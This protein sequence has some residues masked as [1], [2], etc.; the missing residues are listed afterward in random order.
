M[1]NST[2]LGRIVTH[3]LSGVKPAEVALYAEAAIRESQNNGHFNE[4][5]F[6]RLILRDQRLRADPSSAPKK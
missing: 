4:K 6:A 5:D 2:N 3:P 1:K